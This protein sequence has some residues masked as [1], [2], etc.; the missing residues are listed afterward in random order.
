MLSLATPWSDGREEATL[1]HSVPSGDVA[2]LG[3]Q[4]PF[5]ITGLAAS[6]I[7]QKGHLENSMYFGTCAFRVLTEF[8]G[9]SPSKQAS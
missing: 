4:N 6:G 9:H 5:G 3:E 1:S 8:T 7:Q 2:P